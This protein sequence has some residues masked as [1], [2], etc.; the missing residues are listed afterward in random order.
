MVRMMRASRP[1]FAMTTRLENDKKTLR[2][3][4]DRAAVSVGRERRRCVTTSSKFDANRTDT[5][6]E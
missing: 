1:F 4:F 3:L 6:N 5:Q 2:R